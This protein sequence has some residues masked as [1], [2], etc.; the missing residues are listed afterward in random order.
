MASPQ[1]R[2][3]SPSSER[4]PLLPFKDPPGSRDPSAS[5]L[6]KSEIV[7]GPSFSVVGSTQGPNA[8]HLRF[9]RRALGIHSGAATSSGTGDLERSHTA[10]S[11]GTYASIL[12]E[13]AI[14]K[15]QRRILTATIYACH[16]A[17]IIIGAVLTALGPSSAIHAVSITILGATNTTVAGIMALV[18]GQGLMQKLKNEELELMQ[19]KGWVEETEALMEAGIVGGDREEVSRLVAEGYRRYRA[20]MTEGKP[21][22]GLGLRTSDDHRVADSWRRSWDSAIGRMRRQT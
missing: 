21:S 10:P 17:Q 13:H 22:D 4:S 6:S 8:E 16:I 11:T 7:A 3:P 20:V 12:R 2:L 14:K 18:K 19:V 1:F 15:W 5:R 9:F